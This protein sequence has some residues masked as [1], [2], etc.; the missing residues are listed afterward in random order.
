MGAWRQKY[1][2]G[3]VGMGAWG[4]ECGDES[5]GMLVWGWE[6]GDGSSCNNWYSGMVGGCEMLK[7]RQISQ[8][9]M[10]QSLLLRILCYNFHRIISRSSCQDYFGPILL[11]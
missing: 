10:G 2:D 5:M 8:I 7:V 9:S 6:Y 3:S 4:W 11:I 1:V